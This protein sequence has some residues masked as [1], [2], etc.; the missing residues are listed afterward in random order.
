MN[1]QEYAAVWIMLQFKY[2]CDLSVPGFKE[3][4][5]SIWEKWR[6]RHF[7][8]IRKIEVDPNFRASLADAASKAQ[9]PSA[10]SG[11]Q[12]YCNENLIDGITQQMQS[13]DPRYASQQKTWSYLIK[14]L[15]AA[16][17]DAAISCFAGYARTKYR[18]A[19]KMPARF[20]FERNGRLFCY[21]RTIYVVWII[22]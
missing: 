8:E 2:Q 12:T 16:D 11:L 15:N 3:K 13:Y 10:K 7:T 9:E 17:R 14:S 22:S 1:N 6:S 19:L 4:A 21:V 5:A 18:E 20:C